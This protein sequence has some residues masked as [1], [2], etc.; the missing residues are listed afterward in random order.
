MKPK[1]IGPVRAAILSWFGVYG[2]D[3]LYTD[4]IGANSPAGIPVDQDRVLSL[5][6]VWA[7]ARP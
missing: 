1:A 7:C 3:Y 5:S 6:A 4:G 2:T